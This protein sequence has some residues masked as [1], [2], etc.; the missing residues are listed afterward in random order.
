MPLIK[1]ET[2]FP[3]G[4]P[5]PLMACLLGVICHIQADVVLH[6]FVYAKAVLRIWGATTM[7]KP[8]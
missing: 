6:P 7:L 8:P 2:K 3:H 1:A 5:A 4:M